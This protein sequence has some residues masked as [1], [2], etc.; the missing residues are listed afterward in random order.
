[1][2]ILIGF[3]YI[4]ILNVQI[5]TIDARVKNHASFSPDVAPIP[6]LADSSPGT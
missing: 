4:M 3:V 2:K 5:T 1:M 6:S